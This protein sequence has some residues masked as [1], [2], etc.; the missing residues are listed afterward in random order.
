MSP[1]ENIIT[2]EFGSSHTETTAPDAR[3]EEYSLAIRTIYIWQKVLNARLLA[4]LALL[5][6][7][8]IFGYA[9]YEPTSL[10]LTGVTIYSL[11]VLWPVMWLFTRKG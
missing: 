4:L 3:A 2:P 8:G 5:G 7:L 10:R 1:E 6:A 11:G 9:I